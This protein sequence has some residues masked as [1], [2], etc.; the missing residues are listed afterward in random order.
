[1]PLHIPAGKYKTEV[2]EDGTVQIIVYQEGEEGDEEGTKGDN[3]SKT[4]LGIQT[5]V[6][7]RYLLCHMYI[8][9]MIYTYNF[10]KPCKNKKLYIKL[11]S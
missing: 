10:G 2:F 7:H 6:E 11:V 8:F 1:M 4:E 3:S 5:E 9:N